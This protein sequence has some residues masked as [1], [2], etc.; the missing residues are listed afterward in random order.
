MRIQ[1]KAIVI[2]SLKYGDNSLIVKCFTRSSGMKSY[3]IRGVLSAKSKKFKSAFFQPLTLLELTAIHKDK[4]TLEQILE[5]QLDEALKTIHFQIE[6]SSVAVFL[7]EILNMSIREEATHKDMYDFLASEIIRFDALPVQPDFHHLFLI[8]L[9]KYLGFFP[10]IEDTGLYFDLLEGRLQQGYN[11]KQMLNAQQTATFIAYVARTEKAYS[12]NTD[13]IGHR[14]EML[15]HL[16]RYYA[17]QLEGFKNPKSLTVLR[18][19]FTR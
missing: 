15:D 16:L 12:E 7:S 11:T 14:K 19:I 3:L 4:G 13:N 10:D 1:T 17:M 2:S 6:K 18:E 5:V 8:R 9:S